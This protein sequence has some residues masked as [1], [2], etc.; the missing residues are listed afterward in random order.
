M[1]IE[2]TG[3]QEPLTPK[4]VQFLVEE[5]SGVSLDGDDKMLRPD[6]DCFRGLVAVEIKSLEE[7]G[8]ERMENLNAE[9]RERPDW[10]A[11]FGKA[12][13]TKFASHT[14][15]PDYIMRKVTDR[16]GRAVK[17]HIDKAH[18][19]LRAHQIRTE[20]TNLLK[21][22]ILINEDNE[23]YHLDLIGH[24]TMRELRRRTNGDDAGKHIDAVLYLTERH[25]IISQGRLV[26][27]ILIIE[28]G[29]L[30]RSQWKSDLINF[31]VE[32][33]TKWNGN[34][35]LDATISPSEFET[36]ENVPEQ[37]TRSDLWRLNYRRN[38][39]LRHL[40]GAEFKYRFEENRIHSLMYSL[41][42]CPFK[43]P[44]VQIYENL[45]RFTHF[46]EEINHRG[47]CMTELQS[48][49]QGMLKAAY[50]LNFSQEKIAWV[51]TMLKNS[52]LQQ[53]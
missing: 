19:Q 24:I 30:K 35:T 25:A 38:P 11:F 45:E 13:V 31:I 46:L 53:R 20:K 39:Y 22:L 41:K 18:K 32:K 37:M 26:Y 52:K 51:A 9:F 40:S 2:R 10:P 28:G 6:Y 27:P 7:T 3:E 15:D 23:L 14:D 29:S 21:L 33:W 1:R 36:I 16:A 12:D 5:L 43:P 42:D 8:S 49:R 17:N 48:T 4:V 44:Q 34:N 50:R 47:I